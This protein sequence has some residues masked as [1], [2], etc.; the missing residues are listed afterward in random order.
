MPAN[1]MIGEIQMFAG[2]FAP[3]G[4]AFCDGQLLSIAQFS[5]LFSILGTLYGGDGRTNFGLP[6]LQ[7]R[8]PL[9]AGQGPGLT[10]RRLGVKGGA[11]EV[12]LSVGQLPSHGHSLAASGA[13]RTGTPS[14]A[15][16]FATTADG[17]D[18]YGAASDMLDM[19]AST[20]GNSAGAGAPH[21]NRQPYLS[22]NF[23]IA[24]QGVFPSRS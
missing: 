9:H 4:W 17:D 16:L 2:D 8:A 14:A 20:V 21:P 19:A 7:E 23:V 6:D 10:D 24:L 22:I 1:P 15:T 5:A 18:V 11:A 13:G 3:A 12:A